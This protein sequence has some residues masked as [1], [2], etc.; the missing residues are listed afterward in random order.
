[1]NPD[2]YLAED[3]PTKPLIYNL[4]SHNYGI[5]ASFCFIISTQGDGLI[6][7]AN[8]EDV[9][10]GDYDS[11][12]F[13]GAPDLVRYRPDREMILVLGEMSAD[14]SMNRY[15]LDV[16]IARYKHSKDMKEKIKL[17]EI[18]IERDDECYLSLNEEI[19][20]FLCHTVLHRAIDHIDSVIAFNGPNMIYDLHQSLVEYDKYLEDYFYNDCK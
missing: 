3:K 16:R 17:F 1:M 18:K 13:A 2:F 19:L 14:S 8:R 9:I 10:E 4:Q 7:S 15:E 5:G 20:E 11:M 12:Y 6:L